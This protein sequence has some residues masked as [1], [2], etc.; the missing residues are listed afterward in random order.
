MATSVILP[1]VGMSMTTGVLAAWIAEDGSQV[2]EGEPLFLLETEKVAM[3]VLAEA[4]GRLKTVAEQGADLEPGSVVGWL[5]GPGEEVPGADRGTS[6]PEGSGSQPEPAES[7]PETV[8]LQVVDTQLRRPLATP[9]ARR[10]ARERGLDLAD[11][12]GTGPGGRI[13][14][15]DVFGLDIELNSQSLRSAGVA[16]A[17]GSAV[18]LALAEQLGLDLHTISGTAPDGRLSRQDVLAHARSII[19]AAGSGDA[20]Q[21]AP[22]NGAPAAK[23]PLSPMRTIIGRRMTQSLR[24]AP[25]LTVGR[26]V[27]VEKCVNLL[28]Q[29]R[30]AWGEQFRPTMLTF[31]LSAFSRALRANPAAL[32]RIE[33]GEDAPVLTTPTAVDVGVAV[34][35]EG[36]LLVP[37]VRS[38]DTRSLR[39]LAEET[40]RLATAAR[41]GTLHP[42]ETAGA[43]ATVSNLGGAGIEWFTPILNPPETVIL[44]VG[45]GI[46]G[47]RW[48]GEVPRRRTML[49]LSLTFDHRVIDGHPAAVL[50]DAVAQLLASPLTLMT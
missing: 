1:K 48:E 22:I 47:V 23:R 34:A 50:L 15:R 17:S 19:A 24:Q 4:D 41:A 8:P 20:P 11:L 45:A 49:P 13:Q 35:V 30:E 26:S 33:S 40:R 2:H 43:G 18:A 10:L 21:P 5:L 46:D 25:Q 6:R 9:I 42:D 32:A 7:K 12:I 14:E 44:G 38:A 28:P 37:V 39:G 16:E 36:G 3:E 29:L 27:D 31:V